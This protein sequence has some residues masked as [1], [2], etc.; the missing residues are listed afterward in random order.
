[1]RIMR[2]VTIAALATNL[3]LVAWN[4]TNL[5]EV[6]EQR[7]QAGVQLQTMREAQQWRPPHPCGTVIMPGESC[8]QTMLLVI[9]RRDGPTY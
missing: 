5:R 2:W 6:A 8:S 4:V 3:V 9:P 1:M 7:I